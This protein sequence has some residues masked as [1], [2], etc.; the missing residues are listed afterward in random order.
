M[1]NPIDLIRLSD[2]DRKKEDSPD[3]RYTGSRQIRRLATFLVMMLAATTVQA[4]QNLFLIRGDEV[5]VIESDTGRELDSRPALGA[6]TIVGTPGGKFVFMMDFESGLGFAVDFED[7]N[8]TLDIDLSGHAPLESLTFSPDGGLLHVI[9][10]SGGPSAVYAHAGGVLKPSSR[11]T[12]DG[13]GAPAFNSRG[14][15][16]YRQAENELVYFLA[17]DLSEIRRVSVSPEL[18]NWRMAP[19]G[20]NLW[21]V[22]DDGWHIVDEARGR[23]TAFL[24][25]EQ[26]GAPE[27]S[28]DG[29]RVWGLG[30][31]GR[32]IVEAD[33]RR[34]K[35]LN[36]IDIG[37]RAD[38]GALSDTRFWLTAGRN[39]YYMPIDS[40]AAPIPLVTLSGS[41]PLLDI[42]VVEIK[43]GRGFACFR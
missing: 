34:M 15:R 40:S 18:R 41:G 26:P 32:M 31:G 22:S 2:S 11:R 16:I 33:A 25:S 21:G 36:E 17:S 38:K 24:E 43:P 8:R 30:D 12:P 23:V 14:T 20:R 9:P 28:G 3:C 37:F 1:I 6:D 5:L 27:F 29:R 42:A 19:G 7:I 10:E 13:A 35:T 39:L 4:R